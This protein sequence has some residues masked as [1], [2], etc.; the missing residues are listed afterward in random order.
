MVQTIVVNTVVLGLSN[1]FE[2]EW[3]LVH[4]GDW[5]VIRFP[6]ERSGSIH[7]SADMTEFS[8]WI[9]QHCY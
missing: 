2:M 3:C 1:N 9:Y 5:N 8:D 7:N 4:R 6:L